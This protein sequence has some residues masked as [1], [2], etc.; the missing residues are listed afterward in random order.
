M[1]VAELHT[2]AFLIER[3][4]LWWPGYA[5]YVL[6]GKPN[7][8]KHEYMR[9]ML[10][11][12][13]GV[14]LTGNEVH[15]RSGKGGGKAQQ[16]TYHASRFYLVIEGRLLLRGLRV[17]TQSKSD[18]VGG[19]YV[20]PIQPTAAEAKARMA[21]YKKKLK[22]LEEALQ[23]ALSDLDIVK[24]LNNQLQLQLAEANRTIEVQ[25]I[26]IRAERAKR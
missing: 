1:S 13:P 5:A 7:S 18:K 15:L 3:V 6:S 25:T 20:N 26:T 12:G 24:L 23:A 16:N 11:A 21:A 22:K 4:N 10:E 8:R 17:C 19:Y 14:D 2:S 9:I